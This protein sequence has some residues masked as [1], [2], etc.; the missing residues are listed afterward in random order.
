[1]IEIHATPG[2]YSLLAVPEIFEKTGRRS[3]F[4]DETHVIHQ[5]WT[6]DPADANSPEI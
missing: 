6:R 1:M 3:F 2:G 4:S 5:N